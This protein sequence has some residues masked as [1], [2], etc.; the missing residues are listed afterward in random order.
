MCSFISMFIY[1]NISV[2]IYTFISVYSYLNKI[3][4]PGW[5]LGMIRSTT[6]VLIETFDTISKL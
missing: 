3:G 2:F 1:L 4:S 5:L 6:T